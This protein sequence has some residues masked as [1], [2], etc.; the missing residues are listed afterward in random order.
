M[1]RNVFSFYRKESLLLDNSLD[2]EKMKAS[3]SGL[4]IERDAAD[5]DVRIMEAAMTYEKLLAEQKKI[6]AY[7]AELRTLKEKTDTTDS[8]LLEDTLT[9]KYRESIERLN[10]DIELVKASIED[11]KVKKEE[12]EAVQ[13]SLVESEKNN[14]AQMAV[15]RHKIETFEISVKEQNDSNDTFKWTKHPLYDDYEEALLSTYIESLSNVI[16]ECEKQVA[17]YEKDKKDRKDSLVRLQS[18]IHDNKISITKKQHE[19]Q[20]ANKAFEQYND[21]K[22]HIIEG[23]RGLQIDDETLF[24]QAYVIG[25]LDEVVQGKE[26]RYNHLTIEKSMAVQ[27]VESLREGRLM[28][29]PDEVITFLGDHQVDYQYGYEWLRSNVGS[30][31]DESIYL[32]Q[33]RVLPYAL[34]MDDGNFIRFGNLKKTYHMNIVLPVIAE[35]YI[36]QVMRDGA[37]AAT[38][39]GMMIHTAF[40]ER[41]LDDG[42]VQEQVDALN[43]KLM[44]IEENQDKLMQSRNHY[45]VL[46]RDY[47]KFTDSYTKSAHKNLEKTIE[48]IEEQVMTL[49]KANEMS[50]SQMQVSKKTIEELETSIAAKLVQLEM[51]KNIYR[52]YMKLHEAFI[53]YQS[54]CNKAYELK[55]SLHKTEAAI[56]QNE[57]KMKQYLDETMLQKDSLNKKNADKERLVQRIRGLNQTIDEDEVRTYRY[58]KDT[59]DELEAMHEALRRK[60]GNI[61]TIESA[62]ETSGTLVLN[63]EQTIEKQRL[64]PQAYAERMFDSDFYYNRMKDKASLNEKVTALNVQI[65]EQQGSIKNQQE[66]LRG[67]KSEI[68]DKRG[69]LEEDFLSKEKLVHTDYKLR[70]RENKQDYNQL[71]DRL[72][73]LKGIQGALKDALA[74]LSERYEVINEMVTPMLFDERVS[75]VEIRNRKRQAIKDLEEAK[76]AVV[77]ARN[78][79]MSQYIQIKAAYYNRNELLTNMF[80]QLLTDKTIYDYEF[81]VRVIRQASESIHRT[82]EKYDADIKVLKDKESALFNFVL[83]KVSNVYDELKDIDKH[84]TIDLGGK[85]QKMLYIKLPKKEAID[86]SGIIHYMKDVIRL[87]K[88]KIENEDFDELDRYLDNHL[89]L[90]HLFDEY[91]PIGSIGIQISKIE[92]NKVS[93]MS[94]EAVGKASG[95]EL[96]VSVFI[97]FSS[98]ISYTRGYQL[99]KKAQGTVLVMDN[100]FGPVSSEHLLEPLFQIAQTYDSQM[101]C[102]THINTSAITNRFDLIYSL[103][104]VKEGGTGREHLEVDLAKDLNNQIE[105]ID[106][107]LFEIGDGDQ[108]GFFVAI[109]I[110]NTF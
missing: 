43:D 45:Q 100:P 89:K 93:K 42:F 107:G 106:K 74:D 88:M 49:S 61:R 84:S 3:L 30:A 104:V 77:Q 91:V 11:L 24:D 99:S 15:T 35:S 20:L 72:V 78:H 56:A 40:E 48:D 16:S 102:F 12:L 67:Y 105:Y 28:T 17:D 33:I 10:T 21:A 18:T 1:K 85:R 71:M 5:I 96:F 64:E 13:R 98:L 108:I 38:S 31:L 14:S 36:R 82:L 109:Y 110:A 68:I 57:E 97:M 27:L 52:K 19:M 7:E 69:L 101:I 70:R 79:L 75:Q 9:L 55:T 44:A 86:T 60:Q 32:E 25:Q 39:S 34:V 73:E 2:L 83:T 50:L 62:L 92:Q 66:D 103:R 65:L 22:T 94:W 37:E 58:Y 59:V 81:A 29:L 63:L 90:E 46:I 54:D 53:S 8:R 4:E 26:E 23:M 47:Q 80:S 6:M 87:S 41:L 95:G 51:T 76:K